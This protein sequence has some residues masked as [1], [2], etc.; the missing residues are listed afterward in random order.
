MWCLFSI[1]LLNNFDNI[2]SEFYLLVC[3]NM[4][5]NNCLCGDNEFLFK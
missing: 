2:G 1:S 3:F 5:F 4:L